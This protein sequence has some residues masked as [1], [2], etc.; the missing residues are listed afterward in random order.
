MLVLA[1]A[2]ATVAGTN[3]NWNGYMQTRFTQQKNSASGFNIRRAKM[4]IAG[5]APGHSQWYYKVQSIFHPLNKGAFDLQDIFAEYRFHE[6]ALRMGQLVPDFSLQ[7]SQ[8]D[9]NIPVLERAR[10][11]D[12]LIPAAESGGRDIG[13]SLYLHPRSPV[14][15]SSI[16]FFNGNGGNQLHNEDR[17]FL[18]TNRTAVALLHSPQMMWQIGY[19]MM[20]RETEG[21]TFKKIFK[22]S[23][24]FTGTDF[25]WGFE[26][27]FHWQHLNLQAELI[28]ANLN[29]ELAWG[30]YFLGSLRIAEKQQIYLMVEKYHDVNAQTPEVQ[31]ATAGYDY[32]IDE[33]FIKLM[34]DVQAQKEFS[35]INY[36][37]NI[38]MQ[39][40]LKR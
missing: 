36:C 38:Q 8:P 16:G 15:H 9:F 34:A 25:R 21:L 10:V 17:H 4:W 24:Q 2:T 23:R 20:Y 26:T 37:I 14:W 11:I 13:M 40:F 29:D 5:S 35:K 28:R 31:I 27:L 19:S 7:R 18:L 1:L 3:A 22:D 39:L 32:F 30:A 33:Y 12:T 6:W